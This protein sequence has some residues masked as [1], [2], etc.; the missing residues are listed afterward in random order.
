MSA[1]VF[2]RVVG[3]VALAGVI[4]I[5]LILALATVDGGHPMAMFQQKD[6]VKIIC[7]F[8][9]LFLAAVIPIT[10]GMVASSK[11]K[12][13]ISDWKEKTTEKEL[14]VQIARM[15]GEFYVI[16]DGNTFTYSTV[17]NDGLQSWQT[18]RFQTT[19]KYF[20]VEQE[21]MARLKIIEKTRSYCYKAWFIKWP[22]PE[23]ERRVSY[24]LEVPRGSIKQTYEFTQ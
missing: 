23:Y 20:P 6:Y 1:K 4:L 22:E 2:G 5:I 16:Q 11:G 3:L 9:G 10:A 18:K 19:P 8:V 14:V 24:V 12:V 17:S 21:R 15:Y 7:L 13:Y